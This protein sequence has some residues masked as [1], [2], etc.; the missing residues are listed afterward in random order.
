[1]LCPV[2]GSG[3]AVCGACK[4]GRRL[5]LNR[6]HSYLLGLGPLHGASPDDIA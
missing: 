6:A 4:P 1:M 2:W 5:C 3:R